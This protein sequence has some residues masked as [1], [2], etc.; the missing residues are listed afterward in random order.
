M[1]KEKGLWFLYSVIFCIFLSQ[2]GEPLILS[3][4][5]LFPLN[6]YCCFSNLPFFKSRQYSTYIYHNTYCPFFA[7][8]IPLDY[9]EEDKFREA[10]DCY[11]RPL[12]TKV[13][14]IFYPHKLIVV[15][16]WIMLLFELCISHQFTICLLNI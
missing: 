13:I 3:N 1:H 10:A 7:Q 11:V 4:T 8:R 12:L 15:V 9:L 5:C 16:C 2:L 14:G 6:L